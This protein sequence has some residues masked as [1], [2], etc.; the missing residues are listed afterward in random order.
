M[1]GMDLSAYKAL[2][3]TLG[4]PGLLIGGL[5]ARLPNVVVM[6]PLSF[7]AKDASGGFGWAGVVAAAYAIGTALASPW[8]ARVA[9]RR[10]ARKVLVATGF[11]WS[12]LLAVLAA[13]PD[14]W[15]RILPVVALVAG[16]LLPPVSS[17]ARSVWPRIV[18]GRR[19]RTA[20]AL[21]ASAVEVLY[22]VGPLLGALLVTFASPRAGLL[23]AAGV[24][25]MTVWWYAQQQP[26]TV[27]VAAG[28]EPRPT[29]RQLLWHRHRLALIVSFALTVTAFSAVSL[30]IVAYADHHGERLIA[31]VLETVWASGSLLGGLVAGALPGR[32]PS[33]VWRR[34]ALM[35]TGM[36]LVALTTWSPWVMA[37]TM[38]AA[39]TVLAPAV[40]AL[41][42]RLGA[43]TPDSV[44]TEVFGWMQ[45]SAMLGGAAGSALAGLVVEVAGVPWVLAMAAVLVL[46][47]SA[48]L[49]GVPAHVPEPQ[50]MDVTAGEPVIASA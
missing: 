28:D 15:F 17:I 34:T 19:L 35:G 47:G 38:F 36:G 2:W 44:R 16:T 7:L 30:S 23:A 45:G 43:L 21:D 9:D 20:Y 4:V 27:T 11:A 12:A 25:A 14:D 13:M 42:E 22:V 48:V 40:G 32:R 8:W 5:L 37:V 10:G 49:A 1:R 29:L 26:E 24:A 39:G 33:Y 3:R 18:A 46:V 6:I 41:Y 31:G 50:T